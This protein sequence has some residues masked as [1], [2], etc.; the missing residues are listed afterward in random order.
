MTLL[1][2]PRMNQT[3]LEYLK[4]ELIFGKYGVV[5]EPIPFLFDEYKPLFLQHGWNDFLE[6]YLLPKIF[7]ESK[8][9]FPDAESLSAI[10]QST[11][12][13]VGSDGNDITLYIAK[14]RA[15]S[16]PLTG[17]LHTHGGGMAIQSAN[18]L[19]YQAYRLEL[20]SHGFV[21]VSVEFRNSSGKLGRHPY[22]AGLTDCMDGLDWAHSRRESLGISKLMLS[23]ES[24]GGNLCTA[25]AIRA[26]RE[27]RLD[28]FDGVYSLCP[29]I[30]GPDAWRAQSLASMR[31]CDGYMIDMKAF[32]SCGKLYDPDFAH[33][34]DP[35][36]WP[37]KAKP[38]DLEGLPPHFISTNELDPLRDE[39][40]AYCEILQ[41]AGVQAKSRIVKQTPH[42]GDIACAN[43]P[44]CEHIWQE[45]LDSMKTFA[46]SL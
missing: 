6:K 38:A 44:G 3:M 18:D 4:P 31:E 28:E 24:G 25:M 35:C 12:T 19:I 16:G 20:A 13:I 8:I 27:G 5:G 7:I 21:V 46:K 41:G 26:K 22:P 39:G 36:A 10:E 43:I 23:G 11:E 32:R 40:L 33:I 14:P 2:E 30:A 29:F 34:D 45:T 9:R 15:A 37:L 1:T 17:I 42:G